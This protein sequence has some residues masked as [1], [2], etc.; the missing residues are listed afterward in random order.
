MIEV[1][2]AGVGVGGKGKLL[3]QPESQKVC[4]GMGAVMGKTG[5]LVK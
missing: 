4:V 3:A 2:I 5:A 1:V